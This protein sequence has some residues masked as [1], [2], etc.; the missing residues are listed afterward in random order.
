[1]N[2][3]NLKIPLAI[4]LIGF[5]I[6]I[7]V[8]FSSTVSQK[9]SPELITE[10]PAEYTFTKIAPVTDKDHIIG[11]PTADVIFVEYSDTECPACKIFY[12]IMNKIMA[13]FA[14]DGK[15][16]WVYR[17][18]PIHSKSK[19]E[20]IA[21]E[22]AATLGGEKTFW[23]Y[24][25]RIY[26]VTPGNDG[27]NLETLPVMAINLGIKKVDFEKCMRENSVSVKVENDL[28]DALL[29]T[30]NIPET[31]NTVAIFKNP[32]TQTSVE[33]LQIE[34]AGYQMDIG[35]SPDKKMIQ[36][37]GSMPFTTIKLIIEKALN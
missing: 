37:G 35:I 27:L 2:K 30:N 33:D 20:A 15:V 9:I 7:I 24:L 26:D 14:K 17:H 8:Y 11:N 29:A 28:K 25:S 36:F 23:S 1:M 5:L 3:E 18:L 12:G 6:A 16:A 10:V 32:L 31:P 4:I 22:C 21:T 19:A 34:F 13:E